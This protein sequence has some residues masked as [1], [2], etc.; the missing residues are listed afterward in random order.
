MV[1]QINSGSSSFWWDNWTLKGH[2]AGLVNTT[3]KSHKILVSEFITGG[4]WDVNKLK[5]VLPEHLINHILS[6]DIGTQ[7]KED[8]VYW[9][10]TENGKYSNKTAWHLVW[11]SEEIQLL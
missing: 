9:D 4:R 1:W 2:L 7:D 5:N 3:R 11:G 6:L 8:K 10:L